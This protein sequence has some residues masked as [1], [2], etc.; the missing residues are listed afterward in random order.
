MRIIFS[1]IWGIVFYIVSML[2]VLGGIYVFFKIN[3]PD[4]HPGKSTSIA[5]GAVFMFAP[6]IFGVLGLL[7]GLFRKLPGTR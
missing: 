4:H 5:V 2:I 1:L 3:Y 6:L 7:L